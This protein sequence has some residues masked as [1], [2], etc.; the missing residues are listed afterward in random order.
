M[1]CN[2]DVCMYVLRLTLCVA[3]HIVKSF[4][5]LISFRRL[6]VPLHSTDLLIST[7][8]SFGNIIPNYNIALKGN[9]GS[10][11]E[12]SLYELSPGT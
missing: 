2:K 1:E 9:S 8:R 4:N 3:V 6:Y 12:I 7:F 11:Y 10:L 5:N